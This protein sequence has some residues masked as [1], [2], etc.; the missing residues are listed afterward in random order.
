[1]YRRPDGRVMTTDCTT[2]RER[3]WKWLHQRAPWAATA[4]AVVFMAGCGTKMTGEAACLT[5]APPPPPPADAVQSV[6]GGTAAVK[7]GGRHARTLSHLLRLH[8]PQLH[9]PVAVPHNEHDGTD[10]EVSRKPHNT[11]GHQTAYG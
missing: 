10:S 3:V 1:M 8:L 9:L 4:F 11:S 5:G 7:G 6:A 2:K